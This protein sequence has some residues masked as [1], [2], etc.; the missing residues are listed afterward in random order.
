M[1]NCC[2]VACDTFLEYDTPRILL[3]N[4]R[5]IGVLNRLVQLVILA[6]VVGWVFMWEKG[7][8]EFDYPF[9]SVTTKVKGIAFT[10]STEFGEHIW[11]APEY[12]IPPQ[13]ETSF[14]VMTNFIITKNQTQGQCPELPSEQTRCK[15]DSDCA[16]GQHSRHSNGILTGTCNKEENTCEVYGWCPVE[17]DTVIPKPAILGEAENFTVLIK[18]SIT[19]PKFQFSKRNIMPNAT[20]SYLKVCSFDE[21]LHPFCPIFCLGYMVRKAGEDF[22]T[23]SV[24]GAVMG[25]LI[26]WN[27]DLDQSASKCI[28]KYTFERFDKSYGR[29]VSPGYN[30][31]FARY[32][33]N[34]NGTQA[35]N[36]YKAYGIRFV[37]KAFGEA[38]K[39]SIIPTMIN[40]GSGLALLG[41]ATIVCDIFVFNFLKKRN[42][43]K[44]KKY[45]Y[46]KDE[47]LVQ[48]YEQPIPGWCC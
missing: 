42:Y 24:Q 43:Y 34:E 36:L 38:G 31:R 5:T 37:I 32:Y 44:E 13:Q 45:K 33:K 18:N 14:F 46:V 26:E 41:M 39:F 4:N 25:I 19:F 3:I 22:Q 10:N 2:T 16:K 7:Y 21:E 15:S 28:P 29:A 40:I 6:Y 8:Q 17:N 1:N 47:E 48:P 12:V 23:L 27:C 9:S 11:D 35:R 20:A 30:F